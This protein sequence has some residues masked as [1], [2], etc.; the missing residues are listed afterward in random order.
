MEERSVQESAIFQCIYSMH[1]FFAA[2]YDLLEGVEYLW[3]KV[4]EFRGMFQIVE[5]LS[6]VRLFGQSVGQIPANSQL[7]P[8]HELTEQ[9]QLS[10][11]ANIAGQPILH[12]APVSPN[13]HWASVYSLV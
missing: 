5:V 3:R 10:E 13:T 6:V 1:F 2:I 4:A 11:V 7:S 8:L 12:R 9:R